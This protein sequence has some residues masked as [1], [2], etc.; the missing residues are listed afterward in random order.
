MNE[1]FSLSQ[2]SKIFPNDEVCLEEIKRF[3]YPQGIFCEFCKRVTKHYKLESRTA[4][5]CEFCRNHLYPLSGTIFEKSTTSLKLW[6]FSMFLLTITR[7]KISASKLQE[8]V[9][10]TYKTAWRMRHLIIQLMKQNHS[11]LLE[12]KEKV[13]SVSFFNAFE[14][15]IIHKQEIS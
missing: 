12:E 3:R 6:F 9:G 13:L 4:Y 14:L 10:V 5:S 8:E 15:K 2:F 11:D 7:G 1:I